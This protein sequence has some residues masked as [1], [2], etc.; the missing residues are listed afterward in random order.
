MDRRLVL[1]T[2][3]DASGGEF[4]ARCHFRKL[5]GGLIES[6]RNVIKLEAVEFVLKL[7]YFTT[8]HGHLRV[9]IA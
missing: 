8:V 6:S 5:V 4:S 2:S 1:V 9:A 7:T 3:K